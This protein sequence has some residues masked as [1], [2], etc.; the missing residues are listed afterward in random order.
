M[1]YEYDQS[2][3]I[4]EDELEKGVNVPFASKALIDRENA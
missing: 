4:L 2:L 3:D 1:K